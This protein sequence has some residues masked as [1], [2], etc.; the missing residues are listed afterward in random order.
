MMTPKT[1]FFP[2]PAPSSAS[3]IAK[4]FASFWISILRP[5]SFSKSAFTGWPFMQTVLEFFR[6]P[7]RGEIA[8]GV[9]MP[10][11]VGPDT[12]AASSS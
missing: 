3:A 8:P 9:P 7:V 6:R 10:N 12:A 5:S 1:S 2:L 4:Q 11:V